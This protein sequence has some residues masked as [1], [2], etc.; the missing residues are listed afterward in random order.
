M[1]QTFK[2]INK[3]VRKRAISA[4][5]DALDGWMVQIMPPTRTLD[6]NAKIWPMLRDLAEQVTE[7]KAVDQ[8]GVERPLKAEDWKHMATAIAFGFDSVQNPEGGGIIFL[9]KSTSNLSIP[10]FSE[11]IECVYYLGTKYKVKW[12][13]LSK[14][15]YNEVTRGKNK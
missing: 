8:Y 15:N 13:E 6:Q 9:G 12:S 10:K 14:L 4:V 5:L 3:E 2:L 1:K 11:L 7:L